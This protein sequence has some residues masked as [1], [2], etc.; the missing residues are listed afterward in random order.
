[1]IVYNNVLEQQQNPWSILQRHLSLLNETGVIISSIPNIQHWSVILN[2]LQGHWRY[3]DKGII[4]HDHLRFFTLDSIQRLFAEQGLRI[5]EIKPLTTDHD[6]TFEQFIQSSASLLKM[7]GISEASLRQ[8]SSAHQYLI[9][10]TRQTYSAPR[11]YIHALTIPP[12]AAVNLKRVDEPLGFLDSLPGVR[13]AI[14]QGNLNPQALRHNEAGIILFHRIIFSDLDFPHIQKLIEQNFLLVMDFD[15]DPDHWPE[16]QQY[17]YLSFRG[18]HAVQTSTPSLASHLKQYNPHIEVF[19]NQMASLPQSSKQQTK[20]QGK[21]IQ[22]FFGALNRKSDWLPMINALNHLLNEFTEQINC[23]VVNDEEF[24]QALSLCH[25]QFIPRC[26]YTTYLEHLQQ[27]DIALL[28]L[29]DN[30]FNRFKSDL[31]WIESA[32]CHCVAIASPTVYENAVKHKETAM[33]A[34]SAEDFYNALKILIEDSQLRHFIAKNAYQ[35]IKQQRMQSQHFKK[36]YHWYLELLG[37]HK[38]LTQELLVR[39]PELKFIR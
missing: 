17:N 30:R 5:N 10:A 36:R 3:E 9:R 27:S 33:I 25:K 28:P 34:E 15:D 8:G 18:V 11:L 22:I 32:A 21:T 37:Q 7:A 24:F 6:P 29:S 26:D 2:L 4:N 1:C 19:E 39:V 38:E 13:T 14:S 23:V 12:I 20:Q 35:I 16:C 31:K